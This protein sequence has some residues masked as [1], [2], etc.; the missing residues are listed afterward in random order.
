MNGRVQVTTTLAKSERALRSISEVS[1]EFNIPQ[2]VLR[3]WESKFP[4][5]HPVKMSGG[6]RYY[7]P[8]DLHLIRRISELLYGQGYTIKGAQRLLAGS[9]PPVATTSSELDGAMADLESV[10]AALARLTSPRGSADPS[11]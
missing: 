9:T 4:T 6:R 2:H 11:G 10:S 8:E 7:R 1:K 5:L 3:F